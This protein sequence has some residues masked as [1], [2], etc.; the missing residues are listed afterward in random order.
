VPGL[1]AFGEDACGHVYVVSTDGGVSR[2]QDGA[3]GACVLR[4]DA[5]PASTPPPSAPPPATGSQF[6]DRTSPRVR[7]RVARSGRI[8][9]RA[10]PR[11]SLSPTENCR[12]VIRARVARATL[13]RVRTPLRAGRRTI[14]RLRPTPKG[15]KKIHRALRRHKR[16]TMVVSVTAVDAAG[17]VGRVQRRLTLRRG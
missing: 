7:I 16:L 9:R 15:I 2:V 3:V 13:K 10:T 1:A 5:P 8:G 14:V 17:N 11:I 4:F 12:V 6:P